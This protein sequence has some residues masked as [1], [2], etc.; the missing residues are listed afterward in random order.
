M[1]S[2]LFSGIESALRVPYHILGQRCK[3]YCTSLEK[4]LFS[5]LDIEWD[6]LKKITDM[7]SYHSQL[8]AIGI[9]RIRMCV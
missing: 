3:W 8:A 4:Q 5:F 6:L 7:P 1:I 2:Q 9:I